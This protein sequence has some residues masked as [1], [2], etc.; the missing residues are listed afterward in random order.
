MVERLHVGQG[1]ESA[2]MNNLD[3]NDNR[4]RPPPL[5]S[6]EKLDGTISS[7]LERL[8]HLEFVADAGDGKLDGKINVPGFNPPSP[9]RDG[10]PGGDGAPPQ[11]SMASM[12]GIQRLL[13]QLSTR[14][15]KLE[16]FVED[17]GEGGSVELK[18]SAFTA[19]AAEANK[20]SPDVGS[21]TRTIF[22]ELAALAA[23]VKRF[24]DTL[25]SNK[26]F[27]D[28]K[29]MAQDTQL[30]MELEKLQDHIDEKLGHDDLNKLER[31]MRAE[32]QN[33]KAHLE[34]K[35]EKS[36]IKISNDLGA[37]VRIL[38]DQVKT[39]NDAN[40]GITNNLDSRLKKS[41]SMK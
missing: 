34:E 6:T 1:E 12:E 40:R 29:D 16:A 23:R 21:I 8:A 17:S 32:L 13:M 3:V 31:K 20:A 35:Q 5:L 18:S 7:V 22:K 4:S 26:A 38:R 14:L 2:V 41:E 28:Q 33:M 27:Q 9:S 30:T 37:G 10:V 11:P 36:A 15:G 39:V 25:E 24:E 19:A